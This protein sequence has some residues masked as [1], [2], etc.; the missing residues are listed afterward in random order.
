MSLM[1]NLPHTRCFPNPSLGSL[2][3][4]G[5]AAEYTIT[6][7]AGGVI[8]NGVVEEITSLE[9]HGLKAGMYIIILKTSNET[10][11]FKWMKL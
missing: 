4:T 9:L 5:P 2:R 6:D 7:L 11:V 8:S 3:I 10:S 1:E